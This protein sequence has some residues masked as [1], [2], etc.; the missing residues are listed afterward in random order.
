MKAPLID[1]IEFCLRRI[2]KFAWAGYEPARRIEQQLIWCWKTT[3]GEPVDPLP[4]CLTMSYLM[5]TE[6]TNRYGD[7]PELLEA[8]REIEDQVKVAPAFEFAMAA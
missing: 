1:R 7:Y 5:E 2:R 4:S 6:F 8:L 3:N